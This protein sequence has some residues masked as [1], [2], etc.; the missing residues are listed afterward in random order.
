MTEKSRSNIYKIFTDRIIN[1]DDFPR[2][3]SGNFRPS[4]ASVV[5]ST[6]AGPV[7]EGKCARAIWLRLKGIDK[8]NDTYLP[9]QVMRMNVGKEV[10]NS[11]IEQYKKAGIY[12]ANNMMLT[13]EPMPGIII[14][15][16]VDVVIRDPEGN[17]VL[18]EEK[19]IYSTFAQ[20]DNFGH[21]LFKG[22]GPG[23]PRISYLMQLGLYLYHFSR[24][25]KKDPAYA[26]YGIIHV[27]DRGDGHYGFFEVELVKESRILPEGGSVPIHRVAYW[28][29][30]LEVPYTLTTWTMEDVVERYAYVKRHLDEDKMPPRDFDD[31]YSKEKVERYHKAGLI[32][33]SK[34]KKF[35]ASHGPRGKGKEVISDWN[36][37][38]LETELLTRDGWKKRDKIYNDDEFATLNRE[39]KTVEFQKAFNFINKRHTGKMVH[40][41]SRSLNFRVTENHRFWSRSSG[42]PPKV[43]YAINIAQKAHVFPVSAELRLPDLEMPGLTYDM[44]RLLGWA[45]AEG[46][47][48]T[49]CNLVSFA[50]AKNSKYRKELE[51][52]ITSLGYTFWADD[53]RIRPHE[54]CGMDIRKLQSSKMVPN[55]LWNCSKSQIYAWLDGFVKGDGHIP[56]DRPGFSLAQKSEEF[57][58]KMQAILVTNGFSCIKGKRHFSN[59]GGSAINLSVG[60]ERYE[61]Q[62]NTPAAKKQT[63]IEEIENEEV[64]CVS[65]PNETLFSRRNGKV[66]IT[67]NCYSLYCPWSDFCKC[68]G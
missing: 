41:N 65:V 12:V 40:V 2:Q 5:I 15:G 52:L 55:W 13:Y 4:E 59:L 56:N 49:D 26:P 23:K 44:L 1:G 24:L 35:M 18:V 10:E 53:R 16:E 29:E 21:K 47:Y 27:T 38:D 8:T 31:N 46:H 19:S 17:K 37:F 43:N 33:D 54:P 51:Q 6:K 48:R 30:D 36:C 3:S 32:S 14:T 25:P 9:N 64:W 50:K 60:H 28:S 34:H 45:S 7:V 20:R 61:V 58:D 67:M 42:H 62:L 39:T 11:C 22:A 68:N 63:T 66:V 57:I